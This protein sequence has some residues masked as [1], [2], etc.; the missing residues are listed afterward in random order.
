M[1]SIIIPVYNAEDYLKDCISCVVNQTY[2]NIEIILVDDGSKDSSGVICDAAAE[3][4]SRI[5]VI[6]QPN[7]G[8]CAARNVGIKAAHGEY[9]MFV[10][11]DDTIDLSLVEVLAGQAETNRAELIMSGITF[12]YKTYS[13]DSGNSGEM[14][15]FTREDMM[16]A[17]FIDSRM[18]LVLYGPY[19]KLFRN[20]GEHSLR[21]DERLKIGEDLLFVFEYLQ[22]CRTIL[23]V[24]KPLYMYN[25]RETSVTGQ[26]FSKKRAD[27]IF[28]SR[29]IKDICVNA[30]VCQHE[31]ELWYYKNLITFERQL[32]AH[33]DVKMQLPDVHDELMAYL[34]DHKSQHWKSLRPKEKVNL[35]AV[36][37]FQGSLYW[38]YKIKGLM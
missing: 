26:K 35:T 30:K 21:F 18:K 24:D 32:C 22:L 19:N 25:K 10:D 16:R 37:Y 31:A 28:A 4:D 3:K 7:S 8:V 17:F 5:R 29:R 11:A 20:D 23:Y 9:Y 1:V 15:Q 33:K 36:L 6:H 38:L 27:Y 12:V 13:S 34:K 2:S 14:K